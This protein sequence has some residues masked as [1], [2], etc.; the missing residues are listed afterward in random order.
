MYYRAMTVLFLCKV[1]RYLH[2]FSISKMLELK[3]RLKCKDFDWY[4]KNV[5]PELQYVFKRVKNYRAKN[6]GR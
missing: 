5:Y 2:I 6:I 1:L 4:L 3:A